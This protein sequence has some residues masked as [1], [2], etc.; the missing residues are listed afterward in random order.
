MP[1]SG[2]TLHPP[3]FTPISTQEGGGAPPPHSL[4]PISTPG[5]G[6]TLHPPSF[7]PIST[8]EGRETLPP[9][10]FTPISTQEDGGTFHPPRLPRFQ[11]QA[12]GNPFTSLVRPDFNTRRRGNP[13]AHVISI[14]INYNC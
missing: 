5:S 13:T 3:S 12:V 4:T 8:Q 6:G 7:T 14:H 11:R 1:G 9:P 2:G 10:L